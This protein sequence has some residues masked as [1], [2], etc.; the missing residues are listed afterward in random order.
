VQSCSFAISAPDGGN[1]DDVHLIV[2]D[3]TSGQQY[4]V[5]HDKWDVSAD[6]TTATLGGEIC[7]QA[8]G[9]SFVSFSFQFGCVTVP[10]LPA[11]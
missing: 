10:I 2:T 7:D 11:R 3:A 9:G 8:K 4:E 6:H 5:P 1:V